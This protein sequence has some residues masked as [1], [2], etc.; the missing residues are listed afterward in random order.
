VTPEPALQLVPRPSDEVEVARSASTFLVNIDRYATREDRAGRSIWRY[1][2]T[3]LNESPWDIEIVRAG[4]WH[5][6]TLDQDVLLLEKNRSNH[7]GTRRQSGNEDEP[8]GSTNHHTR[9]AG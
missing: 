4:D 6:W 1:H 9:P 5:C 2:V 3:V 7:N 8:Q